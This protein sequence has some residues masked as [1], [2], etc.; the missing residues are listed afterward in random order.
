MLYVCLMCFVFS[1]SHQNTLGL[2]I[3][4][5]DGGVAK[6]SLFWDDGEGIGE[7]CVVVCL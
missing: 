3:A 1:C 4:L 7:F 5:N 2:I 6:G